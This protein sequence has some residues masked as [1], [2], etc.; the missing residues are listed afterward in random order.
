MEVDPAPSE[1]LRTEI[2]VETLQFYKILSQRIQ[3][4]YAQIPDTETHREMMNGI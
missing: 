4:T 3:L 2:L 1:I